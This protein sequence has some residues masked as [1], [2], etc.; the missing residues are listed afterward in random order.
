MGTTEPPAQRVARIA[1]Q[2]HGNVT[3]EQLRG[4]GFSAQQI[5]R[6]VASGS[7]VRRHTG[8]Y[9]VGHRPATQ[10]SRWLAA[11]L[12]L[13]PDAV[14]SHRAA[15]ALWG[16]TRGPTTLDVL[17]PTTAGYRRRDGIV[18]HRAPLAPGDVVIR[19]GIPVTS[20]LRTMLD[21]AAVQSPWELARSFEQAQ[22]RHHLSPVD[23]A[24]EVV[25]RRRYRGNGKLRRLLIGAV[26]PAKVRSVL[27]LR[28]L[29]MCN[30]HGIRRPE[31]NIKMGP[32]MP[33][34]RWE[35]ARLIVETD[36]L[37]FHWTAASR[38]RDAE[39][40]AYM[41]DHGYAVIRLSWADVT[42]NPE[43]TASRVRRALSPSIP[44]SPTSV[45]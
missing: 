27:E 18:V 33:D 28:F 34:F 24:V 22:V 1:A 29:R 6:R 17:V 21:L 32:W 39:K 30:A 44:P 19:N 4:A 10:E 9:A 3:T 43:A 13:G 31:V 5:A 45:A 40:D 41:R 2:Q 25:C 12:A 14:L 15:G 42:A 35:D 37:E 8:V 36:G 16:I 11:V 7:L 20:L 23:L 38:F 26:D